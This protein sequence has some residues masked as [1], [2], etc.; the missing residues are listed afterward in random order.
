[1]KIMRHSERLKKRRKFDKRKK[2][3]IGRMT[4]KIEEKR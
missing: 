1:M 4:W 2:K 3:R